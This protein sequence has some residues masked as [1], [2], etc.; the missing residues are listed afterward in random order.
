MK[1][2]LH[3]KIILLLRHPRSRVCVWLRVLSSTC[4]RNSV[5]HQAHGKRK[6]ANVRRSS[7]D[8]QRSTEK[9]RKVTR[10]TP[11][12]RRHHH[13][14]RKGRQRTEFPLLYPRESGVS[15][16]SNPK[17][18][19]GASSRLRRTNYTR[20]TIA[21]ASPARTQVKSAILPSLLYVGQTCTYTCMY[22][23]PCILIRDE[24][25]DIRGP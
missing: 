6:K 8:L 23:C 5:Q 22:R 21:E 10:E 20:S 4:V 15:L 11:R 16:G 1:L 19:Y 7:D 2:V 13:A 12:P 14:D 18:S 25:L 24:V 9:N 17:P 3:G